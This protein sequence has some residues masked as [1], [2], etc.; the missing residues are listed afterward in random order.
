MKTI[1]GVLAALVVSVSRTIHAEQVTL[2]ERMVEF[3]AII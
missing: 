1:C 3:L 2:K